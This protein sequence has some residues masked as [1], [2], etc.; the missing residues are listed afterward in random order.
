MVNVES[1]IFIIVGLAMSGIALAIIVIII[2]VY[3]PKLLRKVGFLSQWKNDFPNSKI[4]ENPLYQSNTKEE[5][6]PLYKGKD[7][8]GTSIPKHSTV[9]AEIQRNVGEN[10]SGIS[11]ERQLRLIRNTL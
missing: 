6:N 4:E 5:F 9:N 2:L 8:T 11:R 10:E 3:A 1:F 7:N